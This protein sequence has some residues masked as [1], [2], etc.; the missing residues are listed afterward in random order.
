MKHFLIKSI[1]FLVICLTIF[2]F[3]FY[4]VDGY[5]DGMYLKFTTPKQSSLVLGTSKAAQGIRPEILN[6]SLGRNDIYNYAFTVIHSPYG[7][8]YL[9]SI[10][11]KLN[12][13]SEKGI[14]I[15]Q[16]DPY[17]ISSTS[18]DPENPELFREKEGPVGQLESV[19]TNPNIGYMLRHYPYQYNFIFK[20]HLGKVGKGFLHDDGWVEITK[21]MSPIE[22]EKRI[23]T[24]TKAYIE[25][26]STYKISRLRIE[27]L[28]KTINYLK[29]YGQV[30]LVRIPVAQSLFELENILDPEFDRR[31]TEISEKYTIPYFN[32]SR[33]FTE[34]KYLDGN[35]LSTTSSAL[36]SEILAKDIISSTND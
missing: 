15:L 25:R 17:G 31:M 23:E 11:R 34:F 3:I 5:A 12:R 7:P 28:E 21:D 8:Y 30:Y 35:H 2:Y 9:E 32:Y 4:S 18:T 13:A 1:I 20:R 26:T 27:Y 36:F 10:K 14:F 22:V 16:V 29:E 6:K 19:N 33:D 24:K